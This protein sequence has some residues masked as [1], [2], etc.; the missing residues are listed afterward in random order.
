MHCQRVILME[1]ILGIVGLNCVRLYVSRKWLSRDTPVV[2]LAMM[3]HSPLGKWLLCQ[4]DVQQ[5]RQSKNKS[6]RQ[7]TH[8]YIS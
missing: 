1:E 5:I 2:F 7:E 3:Q 6:T 4:K 8:R